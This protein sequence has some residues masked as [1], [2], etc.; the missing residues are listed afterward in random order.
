MTDVADVWDTVLYVIAILRDI[1]KMLIAFVRS[2]IDGDFARFWNAKSESDK[3]AVVFEPQSVRG[4]KSPSNK[5][6]MTLA[7][8]DNVEPK[9]RETIVVPHVKKHD[10]QYDTLAR[11]NDDVFEKKSA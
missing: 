11:L 2:L 3:S 1:C 4:N 8:M 6:G 5:D 10:P 7:G 9:Y